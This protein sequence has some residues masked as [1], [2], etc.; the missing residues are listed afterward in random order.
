MTGPEVLK[1]RKSSST[2][3]NCTYVLQTYKKYG[4]IS[5]VIDFVIKLY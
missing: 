3:T 5:E 1:V 4:E 2:R